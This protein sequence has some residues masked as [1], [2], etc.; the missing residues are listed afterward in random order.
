[1]PLKTGSSKKVISQN[2]AKEIKSGKPKN[3]AIAIAMSKAGKSKK[4][5]SPNQNTKEC[6]SKIDVWEHFF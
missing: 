5:P 6:N 3:Q 4:K 1:M 2:I